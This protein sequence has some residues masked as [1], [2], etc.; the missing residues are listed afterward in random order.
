MILSLH[1][2]AKTYK[3]LPSEA[4]TK[5]TTFDLYVLDI[6]HR[7]IKYQEAKAEG[8]AVPQTPSRHSLTQDRMKE[9]IEQA[10][11]NHRPMKRA[12]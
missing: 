4:L 7:Y 5:G 9:M 6:H 3:L 11:V 1:N 2:L 12:K 8:K 10:R